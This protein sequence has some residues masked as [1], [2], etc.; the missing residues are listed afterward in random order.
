M[1]RT[2]RTAATAAAASIAATDLRDANDHSRPASPDDAAPSPPVKRTRRSTAAGSAAAG[3]KRATAA[4]KAAFAR[5]DPIDD[6]VPVPRD[7]LV[8]DQIQVLDLTASTYPD[9]SDHVYKDFALPEDNPASE[10][11]REALEVGIL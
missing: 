10:E 1:P 7:E 3:A 4:E 8:G 6:D 9:V 2:K 11:L 5:P